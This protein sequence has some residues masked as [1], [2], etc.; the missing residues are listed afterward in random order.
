VGADGFERRQV[1]RCRD[2]HHERADRHSSSERCFLSP[3]IFPTVHEI[4]AT[5]ADLEAV[6]ISAAEFEQ[7]RA[8][9]AR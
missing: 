9:A 4:S 6:E 1:L 5:P 7:E 2:G 3:E 8:A